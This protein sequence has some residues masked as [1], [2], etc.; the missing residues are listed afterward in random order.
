MLDPNS[1]AEPLAAADR[2][3]AVV[4]Q[5][6][7]GLP[8]L[9]IEWAYVDVDRQRLPEALEKLARALALD[10]TRADA[11]TLRGQVLLMQTRSR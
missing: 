2:L 8:A 10:A 5:L 6:A 7:P 11:S 1:R 9:W 4:T 3:Y